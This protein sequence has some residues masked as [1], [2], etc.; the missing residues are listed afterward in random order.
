LRISEAASSLT[1]RDNDSVRHGDTAG[2]TTDD[3]TRL[4]KQKTLSTIS[5]LRF[6]YMR[7]FDLNE[8]VTQYPEWM[9]FMLIIF[10]FRS[11]MII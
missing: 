8:K 9:T 1:E 3:F 2:I 4:Q 7:S 5:L 6:S 11:S 10:V